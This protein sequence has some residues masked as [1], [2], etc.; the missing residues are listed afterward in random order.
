MGEGKI[1]KFPTPEEKSDEIKPEI[2][3]PELEKNKPEAEQFETGG[4][5]IKF[6]KNRAIESEGLASEAMAKIQELKDYIRSLK[7]FSGRNIQEREELLKGASDADLLDR[8]NI[9]N[10][11]DW[12][13][14]PSYY[15]AIVRELEL[16]QR[17]EKRGLFKKVK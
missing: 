2:S 11:S 16:R 6:P 4:K 3:L 8:L 10:Q 14:H 15:A 7:G 12:K 13:V 17:Q 9:S 1:F 5:I